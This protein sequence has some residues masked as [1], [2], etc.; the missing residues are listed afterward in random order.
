MAYPMDKILLVLR[1]A[2]VLL[3]LLPEHRNISFEEKMKYI[4]FSSRALSGVAIPL[5]RENFECYGASTTQTIMV[6]AR[7]GKVE[8][9]GMPYAELRLEIEAA[10]SAI[11]SDRANPPPTVACLALRRLRR[12]F[13]LIGNLRKIGAAFERDFKDPFITGNVEKFAG[14][15]Q[16]DG[17]PATEA[18]VLINLCAYLRR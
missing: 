7:N 13:P 15:I 18:E 3:V 9:Y 5:S 17:A 8:F 12:A 16:N 10:Q 6:L 4:E 1:V 2:A 14:R 11:A